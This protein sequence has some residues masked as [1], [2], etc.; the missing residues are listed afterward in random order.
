MLLK[1]TIYDVI[2][3]KQEKGTNECEKCEI[4]N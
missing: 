2:K 1:S 3:K 4:R